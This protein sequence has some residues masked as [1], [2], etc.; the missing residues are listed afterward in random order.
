MVFHA[1]NMKPCKRPL[2][3][4]RS[5]QQVLEAAPNVVYLIAGQGPLLEEMKQLCQDL[6]IWKS[7]RFTGWL[8]YDSMPDCFAAADLVVMTSSVEQQARMYLEAQASGR[9]LLAS[10]IPGA[11]EVVEDGKQGSCSA[12]VTFST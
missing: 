4:V 12:P 10:D 7:F 3:I 8:P 1:S 5:A 9:I 6:K 11:R 2:D